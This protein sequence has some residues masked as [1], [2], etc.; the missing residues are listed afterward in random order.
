MT[1]GHGLVARN[2]LRSDFLT[3][4]LSQNSIR[5]IVMTP[6]AGNFHFENEFKNDRVI[7]EKLPGNKYRAVREGL[8]NILHAMTVFNGTSRI[9]LLIRISD[10]KLVWF[11]YLFRKM[12]S[13]IIGRFVFFRK[14]ISKLDQFLLPDVLNEKIINKH[15]PDLV[16]C[17][18]LMMRNEVDVVKACRKL[19]VPVIGMV[20]SWDNLVKDI[21]LRMLPDRLVV[22]NEIMLKQA[23]QYQLVPKENIDIVGIPQFDVYEDVIR[24]NVINRK[25]FM[26]SLGADPDKK[27]IVFASEGKWSP[28]DPDIIKMITGFIKDGLLDHHCHLHVRP[29]F[30]WVNFLEPLFALEE[31]GIVSVDK[32]WNE[33]DAFPDR[34]D[35]SVEDMN[36]LANTMRF[37]D[38]LVTSPSTIVLD[39][40]YFDT[41]VINI[42]FDGYDE[43]KEGHSVRLLYETEYYKTVMNYDATTYVN[44]QEMLLKGINWNLANPDG[45]SIARKKLREDFCYRLDGS[46]GKRIAENVISS[47]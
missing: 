34:W 6:A 4:I 22:W 18:S 30:C 14:I 15:Q 1:I 36:H 21:P 25:Q 11:K 46:S 32:T 3:V 43:N 17:T 37:A 31:H 8:I 7:F 16:F 2:L 19:G 41:P 12:S 9:K 20:K 42:G 44:S 40:V 10:N 23:V 29:H 24:N 13:V 28:N 33:S 5:L 35:P 39:G 26:E 45:K 38:V 47:L 27:L